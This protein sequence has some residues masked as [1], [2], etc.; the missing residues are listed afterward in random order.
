MANG[1]LTLLRDI[2]RDRQC[3]IER[4]Y[5]ERSEGIEK[6]LA[7]ENPKLSEL[8]EKIKAKNEQMEKLREEIE[9]LEDVKKKL[10][11]DPW[12]TKE[13]AKE[14]LQSDYLKLRV[15]TTLNVMSK[16]QVKK[17]V[18]QF[19]SKDYFAEAMGA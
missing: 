9:R 15:K 8:T 16:E 4:D 5:R 3:G 19:Q 18:E 14:N 11:P 7:K 12:D 10:F 1:V 13:K 6:Q 17:M 2:Q